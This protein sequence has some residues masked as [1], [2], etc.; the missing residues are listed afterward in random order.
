MEGYI[1]LRKTAKAEESW[2]GHGNTLRKWRSATK[3][4]GAF[5]NISDF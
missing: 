5:K 1:I 2:K 3:V 4:L